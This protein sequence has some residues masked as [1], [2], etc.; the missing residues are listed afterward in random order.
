MKKTARILCERI[1]AVRRD[2]LSCSY[3]GEAVLLLLRRVKIS[4]LNEGLRVCGFCWYLERGI[5]PE[6]TRFGL[7]VVL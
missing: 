2:M 6:R 4:G 3:F 1:Q 5:G 7:I